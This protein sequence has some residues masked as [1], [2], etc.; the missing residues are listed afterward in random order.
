MS[1][2]DD[3]LADG[4]PPAT[5]EDLFR[6]LDELGIEHDTR[7]H[8]P[9]F[10]VE[11]AKEV[12]H[13][14]PGGH[15]K[16]LFLRNKKGAMWLVV[17]EEDRLI[18]LKALAG[19]LHAGRFSFSSADRLMRYLGVV[20]G[21][22]SPFAVINDRQGRVKVV[23]DLA[24]LRCERVNFHPLDNTMSTAIAGDDLVKFLRAENHAP[25]VTDLGSLEHDV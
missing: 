20:P 24:V 25:E 10:T 3:K 5:P 4:R 8:Q 1:P 11:E 9:V 21:A 2:L 6:R 13:G 14:V 7:T 22:V 15:T 16:N 23:V 18:D 19:H 12:R 17:C